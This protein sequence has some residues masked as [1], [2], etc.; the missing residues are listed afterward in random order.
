MAKLES[1]SKRDLE[2][3]LAELER[4]YELARKGLFG[5]IILAI[6]AFI[7]GLACLGGGLYAFLKKGPGFLSGNQLV[8]IYLIMAFGFIIYF[9]FVF[10]R[11]TKLKAQI[12]K[13]KNPL[14]Q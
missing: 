5:G 14:C 6:I 11:T 3:K 2:L 9:S 7:S 12:T 1:L 13:T 8:I 10:A 4:E